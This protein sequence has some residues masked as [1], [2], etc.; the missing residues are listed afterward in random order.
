[1]ILHYSEESS[2]TS[3]QVRECPFY[4]KQAFKNA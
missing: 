3:T 1:M 4:M 2:E